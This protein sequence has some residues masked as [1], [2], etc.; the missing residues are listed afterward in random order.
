MW[1]YE[2]MVWRVHKSL[3]FKN[4]VKN[5]I[6]CKCFQYVHSSLPQKF[7]DTPYKVG[8]YV[9]HMKNYQ[10][11]LLADGSFDWLCRRDTEM[12][13]EERLRRCFH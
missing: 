2:L 13:R 10:S 12:D 9:H 8:M 11:S 4:W 1:E 7:T 6:T 5:Q 3:H